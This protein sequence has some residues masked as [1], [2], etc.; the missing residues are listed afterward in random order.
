M[1]EKEVKGFFRL[2]ENYP[3]LRYINFS[4]NEIENLESLEHAAYALK[5]DLSSN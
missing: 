2:I 5:I 3:H 4:T 1:A